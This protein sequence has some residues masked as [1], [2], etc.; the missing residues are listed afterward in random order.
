[1]GWG[2]QVGANK[3]DSIIILNNGLAVKAFSGSGAVRF[4][5][6]IGI[7]VGPLGREAAAEVQASKKG[8][9]P[10]YSY[11]RSQGLFAGISLQGSVLAARRDENKRFYGRV[12]S[13]RQIL[14]G[15]ARPPANEEL[16]RLIAT[17]QRAQGP[18]APTPAR[19]EAPPPPVP[20]AAAAAVPP[21]LQQ[22]HPAFASPAPPPPPQQPPKT[23]YGRFDAR[24]HGGGV[25][26][27]TPNVRSGGQQIPATA[28]PAFGASRSAPG[29]YG[30]K[31][32]EP[33]M[34]P[35]AQPNFGAVASAPQNP[36]G[37]LGDDDG[38]AI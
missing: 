15:E 28:P 10:C 34:P 30:N 9:S 14:T 7:S 36:F 23:T 33:S 29:R 18:A 37:G 25:D 2:A 6:D 13:P 27:R 26:A 32:P 16:A 20:A 31:P 11:S 12:V 21:P 35:P 8:G 17:L 4:G 1:M 38:V 5:A 19:A 3:T 24:N 22:Q